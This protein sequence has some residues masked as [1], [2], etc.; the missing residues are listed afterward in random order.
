MGRCATYEKRASQATETNMIFVAAEPT[1]KLEQVC[2]HN[3]SYMK[4]LIIIDESDFCTVDELADM[5]A[6]TLTACQ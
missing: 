5:I 3:K 2:S 4:Y 6:M 1:M